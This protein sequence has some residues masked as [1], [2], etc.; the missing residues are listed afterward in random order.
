MRPANQPRLGQFYRLALVGLIAGLAGLYYLYAEKDVPPW[1]PSSLVMLGR[2]LVERHGIQYFDVN[3]ALIGPLF[4]P[5]GFDIRAPL[6]PQ[7]YSSFPPGFSLLV[8]VLYWFAGFR[9]LSVIPVL[10]GAVGLVAAAY[11]GYRLSGRWGSVL[12]VL[13][14]G[15]S[16]VVATFMTS[17]W[18]DGPSL[19]LLLA[20]MAL[21]MASDTAHRSSF[22][23][24]SGL[25]LGAFVSFKFVNV[26]FVAPILVHQL[27]T[28][29]GRSG[30][31][32]AG[33]LSLGV[34]P[35]LLLML[36]YQTRAY[37]APF[38]NAYQPWGQ[39]LFNFPLF[40][41]RYLVMRSPAPWNDVAIQA[42][43]LGIVR[44]MH[45]W[46]VF[47]L[48]GLWAARR[49]HYVQLIGL[50]ALENVALYGL[51]VFSPRQFIN[52]RY[53][54]PALAMGYLLAA[55][56]LAHWVRRL[57]SVTTKLVLVSATGVTCL[58]VLVGVV[59]PNL[60]ERNAGTSH[61]ISSVIGTAQTLPAGSVVL[62][63][64]LA[65]SFILYGNV[66]VLN[67]RRI[68]AADLAARNE[69][70]IRAVEDLLCMGRHVYL[71]RDDEP[72]FNSIYPALAKSFALRRGETLLESF[73]ITP[74]PGTGKC[75]VARF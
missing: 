24:L 71:I 3:N 26:V 40:S 35:G 29:P 12:A 37:G 44:D 25:C 28:R 73:E 10:A 70:A 15:T 8:A 13:L 21:Y 46:V 61:T 45:V 60:A 5:H 16:H 53:L 72:L 14:I 19:A 20:G 56:G 54:L 64:S 75:P 66:S 1:D 59:L 30:R 57:P 47:A 55:V 41:I 2:S 39:S 74:L 27:L 23:L 67:Y 31:V 48:I 50:I 36:A 4:N 11:I 49:D 68:D 42:I 22:L 62:A 52:M 32:G 6:D 51:S 17:L 58:A 43:G 63:Y 33:M 34:L 9:L 7:P 69:I 65:D 18:S 38:A